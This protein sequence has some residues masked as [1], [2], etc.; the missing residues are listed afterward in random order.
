MEAAAAK[1]R[2]SQSR[3]GEGNFFSRKAAPK[4]NKPARM[5]LRGNSRRAAATRPKE[6]IERKFTSPLCHRE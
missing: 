5:G 3:S 2:A 1:S 6:S 4:I